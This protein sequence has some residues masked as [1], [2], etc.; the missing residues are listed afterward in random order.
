MKR[1]AIGTAAIVALA[2][3]AIAQ[4]ERMPAECRQE[5][6]QL[7]RGAEGGIRQCLR[8]ALPKLSDACRKAIGNRSATA[9][10][11][12]PGMTEISYGRDPLQRLDLITPAGGKRP[13]LIVFVHGGGWS[14]GDN[15]HA[16]GAKAYHVV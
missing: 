6:M 14:I 11:L 12:P 15:S 1:I 4:R 7:C 8:T 16:L 3:T 9:Q 2:G 10:P 13:P 5:I